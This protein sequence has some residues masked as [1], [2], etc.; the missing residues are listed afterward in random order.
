MFIRSFV[1]V[2]I[3]GMVA[4]NVAAQSFNFG[5]AKSGSSIVGVDTIYDQARGF[6]FEPGAEVQCG[7]NSCTSDKPYYFSAKV[8]EGNYRVTVRFGH[9]AF[10]TAPVVKAELRRLMLDRVTTTP[11]KYVTKSFIVNVR[12]PQ[13]AT[14]GEVKLK[15]REKTTEQWAWDDKLTLEFNGIQPSVASILIEP[16]KLPTVFLLGDSTVCDQPGEPY[17]SWGQM[18]TAFFGP[19][20]AIANHAES[21]ES[22]R[23]SYGA[24]RL[25][26]VVS[27]IK[28]GDFLLIQYGHNDMKE[29]GEGVGAFRTYKDSLKQFT[30]AARAKGATVILVSPM[31]RRTFDPT[32]KFIVNSHGDYPASVRQAAVEEKVAFIDLHARSKELYEA[33]GK[34]GSGVLFKEGD[35]THHNAFG[36]NQLAKIIVQSILDQNMPLA[37]YLI[38]DRSRFDPRKPDDP[39]TFNVPASPAVAEMKPLGS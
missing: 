11:A 14:G 18:I 33:F 21:G 34:D 35:G 22:L 7:P 4:A 2:L 32:G 29:R 15:D 24:K 8:P 9:E 27:L 1:F 31:H 3:S 37:K 25:D 10:A 19:N 30:A 20:V 36:A 16:V 38:K 5:S 39:K 26:K 17:A 6:G 13:I 28:P 12:T 23:S